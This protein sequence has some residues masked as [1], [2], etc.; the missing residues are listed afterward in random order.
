MTKFGSGAAVL[1]NSGP[2][3]GFGSDKVFTGSQRF[4]QDGSTS[5]VRSRLRK[6]D[7]GVDQRQS[8]SS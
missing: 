1:M 2:N 3:V 6:G 8:V 5:F 7:V 4:A